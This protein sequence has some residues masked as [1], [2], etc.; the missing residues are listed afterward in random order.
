MTTSTTTPDNNEIDQTAAAREAADQ[1]LNQAREAANSAIASLKT[2]DC[3]RLIYL[4]ALATFV[5]STLIFD[6]ASFSIGVDHAVSETVAQAQRDL[7]AR[8]NSWSYPIF[9]STLWG[10]LAWLSA[11]GGVALVIVSASKGIRAAWIPL[12][13]IGCAAICTLL[14]LLLFFVGFPDLSAYDDARCSAT[15]FGY[16]LPF[17]AAAVA[18]VTSARR[19]FRG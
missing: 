1:A 12:A 8:M 4:A 13:E 18:T 16:W 5:V 15:L 11:V 14:L 7:Q 19:V 17:A 9:T 2:L 3:N 6:M 10:K